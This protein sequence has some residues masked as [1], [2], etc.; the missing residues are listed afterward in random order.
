M[1]GCPAYTHVDEGKLEPRAKKYIFLGYASGMKGFRL[2]CPDLKSPKFIISRDI[3]FDEYAMINHRQ[4]NI[5]NSEST[6]IKGNI[7]QIELG[8]V[9]SNPL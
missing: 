2:W 9:D 4:K 6:Q 1:F 7:K 5:I 3:I 8:A